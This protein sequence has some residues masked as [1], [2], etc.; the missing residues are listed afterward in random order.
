[1][2]TKTTKKLLQDNCERLRSQ[3]EELEQRLRS[4][5][6][7]RVAPGPSL[8]ERSSIKRAE[9]QS[10]VRE[11]YSLFRECEQAKEEYESSLA[12]LTDDYQREKDRLKKNYE[13]R[14]SEINQQQEEQS[15]TIVNVGRV[16]PR[17]NKENTLNTTNTEKSRGR[18]A[19]DN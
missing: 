7:N 12:K 2:Q 3:I 6:M 15:K 1:M 18:I 11:Q 9:R 14:I 16:P 17:P 8:P 10:L 19:G 5:S 13:K 4:S